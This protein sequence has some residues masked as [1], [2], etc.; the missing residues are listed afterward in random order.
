MGMKMFG[1]FFMMKET[2]QAVS[3]WKMKDLRCLSYMMML[4]VRNLLER[5]FEMEKN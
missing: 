3:V 5:A 2:Q 4:G 1:Y